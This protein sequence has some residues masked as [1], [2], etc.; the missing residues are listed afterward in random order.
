MIVLLDMGYVYWRNYYATRS[1]IDAY[2]LTVDK[3]REYHDAHERFAVCCDCPPLRRAQKYPEYKANREE[4]PREALDSLR[5]V[6]QQIESWGVPILRVEGYEAD[7]LIAALARQTSEMMRIVSQDKDLYALITDDVS[8]VK[9]D[10]RIIDAFECRKKF[11]IAPEQILDFLTMVGDASDNIPGCPS[12]GPG[13]ARDLLQRFET[14]DA[15]RA[16]TD[17]DLRAVRGV[18]EK[19]LTAIR[20][21]DPALARSLVI[22]EDDAPVRLADLWPP[23]SAPV[24]EEE[25]S[26]QW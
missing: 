18:G 11:G 6:E 20:A 23:Q 17:E 24:P 21:W 16:A 7:D 12:V 14:L 8:L 26:I 3:A 15:I 13:R 9:T 1:D 10:G 22:L 19:T 4:K 5:A 25:F 2:E